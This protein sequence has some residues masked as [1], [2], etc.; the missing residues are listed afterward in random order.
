MIEW[1]ED[2]PPF[3]TIIID[4]AMLFSPEDYVIATLM[5]HQ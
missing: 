2:A 4:I 3:G 1:S 5:I